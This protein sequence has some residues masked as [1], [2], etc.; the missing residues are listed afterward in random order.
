MM[1]IMGVGDGQ[2]ETFELALHPASDRFDADDERWQEQVSLLFQELQRDV[3]GLCR[4]REAV[5]GTKGGVETVVLALGSAGAFTAGLEMLRAWLAR[6]RSRRLD[7][8][9]TIDGRS[10][11]IAIAGDGIDKDAMAK[12]SDA[13]AGRLAGAA[14]TGT[15]PS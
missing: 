3:G 4:R 8:S 13:V 11:V 9:Y 7:I 15:E 5:D 12:L 2:G 10:E 14:W 1:R 6:D